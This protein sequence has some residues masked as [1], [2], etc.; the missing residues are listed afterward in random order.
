MDAWK[1]R[2]DLE[3]TLAEFDK[4]EYLVNAIFE[5][6]TPIEK[7]NTDREK[8]TKALVFYEQ[9]KDIAT[10][11]SLLMDTISMI[12]KDLKGTADELN[13]EEANTVRKAS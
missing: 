7:A 6:A 11:A 2:N 9:R 3:M 4:L 13:T 10:C 5:T 12:K 1:T 8:I